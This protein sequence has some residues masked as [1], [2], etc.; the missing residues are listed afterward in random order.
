[1]NTSRT[2]QRPQPRLKPRG[3]PPALEAHGVY[4]ADNPGDAARYGRDL[5][6]PHRVLVDPAA[7]PGFTATFHGVLVRDVTLGY[8]DYAAA[9]TLDIQRLPENCLVIVPVTGTSRLE[10]QAGVVEATP[11]T[12]AIPRPEEPC[13][14]TCDADTAH[15]VVRISRPALEAHLTRLLGRSIDRRPLVFEPRFDLTAAR[16]SRWSLAIQMLLA[17]L[18]E[19]ASLLHEGVGAGSLEEFVMSAL[20]YAQPSTFSDDLWPGKRSERR[21]VREARQFIDTNLTRPLTIAVIAR[22]AGVSVRG[23]QQQ[24]Q[25]DLGQTPTNYLRDRRL[26]RARAD[27]ADA[28]PASGITVAEIASRWGFTHLGRFAI[29]YR[30]RFGESPSQT[31]RT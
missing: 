26:E 4:Q 30:V 19:P 27:L 23:L 3:L 1:V 12:A 7:L 22:A 18:Y 20:L 8:L 28:S 6:G 17:E 29:A 31:I 2:R 14:I 5:L 24:F 13:T 16:A 9:V 25:A 10:T 15:L 21:A 11:V